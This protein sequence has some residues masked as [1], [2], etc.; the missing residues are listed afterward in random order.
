MSSIAR[1]T[2]IA[3]TDSCAHGKQCCAAGH[4]VAGPI[5]ATSP[6]V[7]ANNLAVARM[8]DS[9]MH[10]A[11]CGQN[12][13]TITAGSDNVFVNGKKCARKGD[14]TKHCNGPG[15]GGTGKIEGGSSDVNVN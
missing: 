15:D 14:E 3:K 1:K 13:F 2:D 8:D 10:A 11:C 6:N 7:F 12:K 9:G 5:T 4:V